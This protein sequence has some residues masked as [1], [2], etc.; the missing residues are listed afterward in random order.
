M[1]ERDPSSEDRE[2]SRPR[3]NVFGRLGAHS[4]SSS[5]IDICWR[6]DPRLSSPPRISVFK[7]IGSKKAAVTA[8]PR[9]AQTPILVR[10]S[11]RSGF[12]SSSGSESV[13]V[14]MGLGRGILS[15]EAKEQKKSTH[16]IIHGPSYGVPS[17]HRG[18]GFSLVSTPH[19]RLLPEGY[20]FGRGYSTD[21]A[22]HPAT[23]DQASGMGDQEMETEDSG[24]R[25]EG[26]GKSPQS[27]L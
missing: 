14:T 9:T 18:R 12:S 7:R 6:L 24:G 2:D 1:S 21:P 27:K 5:L 13:H 20:G 4:L 16:Q 15:H 10:G 3:G 22:M 26:C 25:R 19:V 23:R 17:Q 11:P 8:S